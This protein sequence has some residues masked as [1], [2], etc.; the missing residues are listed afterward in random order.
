[1]SELKLSGMLK[2]GLPVIL[3]SAAYASSQKPIQTTVLECN[4]LR[5]ASYAWD[6]ERCATDP[7]N[8][9]DSKDTVEQLLILNAQIRALCPPDT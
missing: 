1:M 7:E 6:E 5:Q 9:C 2:I 8:V 3:M 4:E